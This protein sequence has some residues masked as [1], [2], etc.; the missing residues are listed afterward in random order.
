MRLNPRAFALTTAIIAGG[1]SLVLNILSV[2]T[3]WAR[4]FFY[5]IA[6]FHPGYSFTVPGAF[7]GAFWMFIYGYILGAVFAF[8]YNLISKE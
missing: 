8:I 3:G 2:L 5:I 6:P 4:D 1:L 7:V